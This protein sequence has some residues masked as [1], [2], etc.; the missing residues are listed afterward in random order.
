M[1]SVSSLSVHFTGD[2]LF[3][4]VSFLIGDRDRIGL[5]GKNGAGKT[6]LMRIIAGE[7][8]PESGIVASPSGS[9]IGYLPQQVDTSSNRN[10]LDETMTAFAEAQS[11]HETIEKYTIQLAER[12][13]YESDSYNNLISRLHDATDRFHMIGGNTIQEETE[14][15]L[16]GLG[17]DTAEFSRP[18]ST[19][20]GGWQ[21][22]IELAKILLRAPDVV[23]LD[24]P[25]NHLD[26]ES[27]QWLEEFLIAYRG[28]VVIVSHDRAFLDNVTTRTIEIMS[29]KIYDFKAGYSEYVELRTEQLELQKAAY[30]NQQQQI[31]Q[32][33]R[34]VE[35]FR[36]KST[37]ARQ[38]QSRIKML[39]KMDKIE[40]DEVDS[41]A[42]HFRFPPAPRS[43]RV[44]VEASSLTK[45]FG[46]KLVLSKLDFVIEQGDFVA[47]VGRNGE[48]KTT[49]AKIITG[50]LQ[51][52]GNCKIGH[53]VVIGYYAQNQA[54]LLDPEKTVFQTIDEVAVGDI[55]P[56]VRNILGSFLFGGEAIEK[57]VK[58]LSGG[59]KARLAIAQL[60]LKPVNLLVLDEPT[61]HLDMVSK[62]I[63]KNALLRFDGTLIIV[64]HDRD[65]LQGLTDKVFEF[66]NHGIKPYLGDVYAFLDARKLQSLK[67]LERAKVIKQREEAQS[68]ADNKF[69]YERRKQQEREVRKAA[70]VVKKLEDEISNLERE[71]AEWDIKLNDPASHTDSATSAGLFRDYKRLKETLDL[72]VEQWSSAHEEMEQLQREIS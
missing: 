1:I 71:I 68:S 54:E 44:V 3:Q 61:N 22:R 13:D 56:R 32:I 12:T 35:R 21:M 31:A 62:D 65:F 60:L 16:K 25:T 72:K 53:N 55:R 36:Y 58:V 59:E 47:F 38:V 7:M 10:V 20:S 4:D 45:R 28:A 9:T 2:Y 64:S 67:E 48:G 46:E 15:V 18:V 30:D 8:S 43:G 33:E 19:L 51:H 39:D 66:R 63:L 5:V 49:L 11:L 29:G 6:T 14:K 50:Y 41:S 24:E 17:F 27:I 34:F 23:L 69:N 57:K 26:I 40:L 52:E 70:S 37:K 42:I